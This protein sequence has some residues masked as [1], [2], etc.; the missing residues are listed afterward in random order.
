MQNSQ[1]HGD[2]C[3]AP[4][5]QTLTNPP[6]PL[7]P[8][9][10]KSALGAD[11]LPSRGG[12]RP[13]AT[14]WSDHQSPQPI[15]PTLD[16]GGDVA[17]HHPVPP[18]AIPLPA[19]G[20]F[21]LLFLDPPFSLSSPPFALAC[22]APH[23]TFQPQPH[24]QLRRHRCSLLCTPTLLPFVHLRGDWNSLGQRL[25]PSLRTPRVEACLPHMCLLWASSLPSVGYQH[26]QLRWF[27]LSCLQER[28]L[29]YEVHHRQQLDESFCEV[30]E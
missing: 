4:H 23:Q 12:R 29:P 27:P 10:Q 9:S 6:R 17:L 30:C 22:A 25:H 15:H 21:P 24:H 3:D 18:V 5:S 26:W 1:V 8:P 7:H 2:N 28:H 16:C 19:V 11:L 14:G 13:V 20:F